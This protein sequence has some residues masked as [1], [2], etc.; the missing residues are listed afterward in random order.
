LFYLNFLLI[1][2][3]FTLQMLICTLP[4]K[5]EKHGVPIFPDRVVRQHFNFFSQSGYIK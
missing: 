2:L 5:E 1:L 3:G 4:P